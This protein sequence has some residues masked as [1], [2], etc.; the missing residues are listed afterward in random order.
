[1]EELCFDNQR[2]W[3]DPNLLQED[4]KA[5]FDASFWQQ[6]G[7]VIGSAQGRGTTWFVQGETLP[8]ALRHYR[9][10]GLFGKLVEDAYVFT[11]WEKTRCAEEVALLSTL[12]AGGVNVPRPVAAR[13]TRHGL[14]YRADLLVEKI[15]SAKDLV[16]L[17]QQAMLP[18]HVWCAI[19]R[20]VRKMHDL[21]KRAKRGSRRIC[22][23]Y[24]ALSS[25]SKAS[26]TF[27]SLP[28]AGKCCVR[29]MRCVSLIAE[30][31]Q[32]TLFY[33]QRLGFV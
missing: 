20:T 29:V 2:I 8:M 9:R 11:G 22:H 26:V 32:Q 27:I 5:C 33:L 6:Q 19:G 3:F 31:Q 28:Q 17:L 23:A 1:V 25:K 24:I 18:D 13:A 16:A 10:G 30:P 7:K 14:V 15:D 12:A 21:R 4:P